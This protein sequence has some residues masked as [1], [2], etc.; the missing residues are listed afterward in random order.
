MNV[1]CAEVDRDESIERYLRGEL[2]EAEARAL[3]EHYFACNRCFEALKDYSALRSEF[4]EERWAVREEVVTLPW[5]RTWA[6]VGAAA[7]VVLAVG[8]VFWLRSGQPARELDPQI[9]ELSTIEAP[10]YSPRSL[11]SGAG[12]AESLFREAMVLYQKSEFA[13]AIPGLEAAV[14]LDPDLTS[15]RFYLG[16]SYLLTSEYEKAVESLTQGLETDDLSYREWALWLRSK[17]YLG[18]GEVEAARRDLEAVIR[19]DGE[20]RAQAQEVL[21]QLP[22]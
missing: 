22:D 9:A 13:G 19:L 21:N 3:E 18:V 11:R 14:D 6:W 1:N 16:A 7:A 15:A 17:A 4:A 10:P 12:Q 20:L 5:H 2:G 8:V